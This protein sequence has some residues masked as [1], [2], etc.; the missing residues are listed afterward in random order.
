MPDKFT[1]HKISELC[2]KAG[3]RVLSFWYSLRDRSTAGRLSEQVYITAHM[4]SQ[5]T[6]YSHSLLYYGVLYHGGPRFELTVSGLLALN[7]LADPEMF[8]AFLSSPTTVSSGNHW[9]A[10]CEQ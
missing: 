3:V 4:Q 7:P 10:V 6:T 2:Q 8:I 5:R 1:Y 9:F